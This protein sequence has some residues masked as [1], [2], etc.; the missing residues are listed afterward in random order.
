MY[1]NGEGNGA[2]NPYLGVKLGDHFGDCGDEM[3]HLKSTGIFLISLLG[4]RYGF[5][6]MI[7]CD[8]T[9][10]QRDYK[11][12]PCSDHREECELIAFERLRRL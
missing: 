6:Q 8:V 5:I 9:A 11:N 1:G 2:I 3:W 7:T 4:P 12:R 10:S